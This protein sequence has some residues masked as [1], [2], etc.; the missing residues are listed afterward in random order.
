MNNAPSDWTPVA[1]IVSNDLQSLSRS[2]VILEVAWKYLDSFE[3]S[4][5]FVATSVTWFISFS[6]FPYSS[7]TSSSAFGVVDGLSLNSIAN[8]KTSEL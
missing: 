2:L 1:L 5:P 4:N 7:M 3:I 6:A 8:S